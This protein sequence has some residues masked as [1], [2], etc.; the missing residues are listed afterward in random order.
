MT[1]VF[2]L[3]LQL[4]R[5]EMETMA[6][7]G[8]S[9]ARVTAIV[10]AEILGVLA[11]GVLLA[12]AFTLADMSLATPGLKVLGFHPMLLALNAETNARYWHVRDLQPHLP[13]LRRVEL[14]AHRYRGRGID[15]LFDDLCAHIARHELTTYTLS[16]LNR[17][18]EAERTATG[19]APGR[20][21]PHDF[22]MAGIG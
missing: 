21:T 12:A 9:R 14:D 22:L 13:Q 7:I 11:S 4:R 6:K 1:M 10:A 19:A 2:A 20:Y 16:E 5:R 18:F 17:A 3:S 15:S 8:A